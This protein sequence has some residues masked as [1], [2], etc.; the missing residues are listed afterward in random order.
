MFAQHGELATM[1]LANKLDR[2]ETW[3]RLTRILMELFQK[4]EKW[5]CHLY[6]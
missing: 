3:S 4:E 5:L 6:M 2:D 1:S